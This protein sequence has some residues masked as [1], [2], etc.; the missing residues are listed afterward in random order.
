MTPNVG[1]LWSVH[2]ITI[3]GK[4]IKADYFSGRYIPRTVGVV[5]LKIILKLFEIFAENRKDFAQCE[6]YKL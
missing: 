3:P 1:A 2:P 5:I 6:I 4:I